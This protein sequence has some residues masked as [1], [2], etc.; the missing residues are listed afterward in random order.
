MMEANAIQVRI[1]ELC[2]QFRLPTMGV[3]GGDKVG[4]VGGRLLSIGDLIVYRLPSFIG[5]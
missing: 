5:L 2:H 3:N 4:R 1:G